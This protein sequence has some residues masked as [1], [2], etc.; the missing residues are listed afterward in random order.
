MQ[1]PKRASPRRQRHPLSRCMR[2]KLPANGQCLSIRDRFVAIDGLPRM[3]GEC[4]R[5][6]LLVLLACRAVAWSSAAWAAP[7]GAQTHDMNKASNSARG[8]RE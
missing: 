3:A 7:Q 4:R 8:R 6:L 2:E 5:P 1:A